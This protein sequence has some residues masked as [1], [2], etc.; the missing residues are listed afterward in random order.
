[1]DLSLLGLVIVITPL[2]L[3]APNVPPRRLDVRTLLL[4]DSIGAGLASCQ[5]DCPCP[6]SMR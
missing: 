1:M 5:G 2:R 3:M 6:P 4:P